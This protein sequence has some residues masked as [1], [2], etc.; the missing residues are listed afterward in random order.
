[1][2]SIGKIGKSEQ[3]QKYYEETVAKSREDYYA[4]TGEAPGEFFGP[5]LGAWSER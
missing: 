2:L 3:Q 5:V 1:M 4:G